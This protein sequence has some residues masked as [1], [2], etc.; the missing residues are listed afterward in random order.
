MACQAGPSEAV[1]LRLKSRDISDVSLASSESSGCSSERSSILRSPVNLEETP[2]LHG[3]ESSVSTDLPKPDV[4]GKES[5]A[6]DAGTSSPPAVLPPPH[7]PKQNNTSEI[8]HHHPVFVKDTSKYWYKPTISREQAINML[9]DK[10]P[11]TFVVRDSNSFPGA[12]GLAL[13]V[14]TPPPGVAP[15][16]G[17]ELVRHFLIEPSPK[18]VK[19]KG[20]NNEPVFGSLSA[21]VYQHS[22]TP[23]ALPT[24]LLLPEYDP[25]TTPEHVSA[26]QALLEQGAACN[27]AYIGSLDCESLTGSECVRRAVA[28]TVEDTQRGL[29]RPVS[30]HFKVSSQGVTLTDNTRKVFFRRHFPVNTVIFAGMDPADRKF[31]NYSVIGF[32]DQCVKSARLFAIVA[33]KP[34][35]MENACHVFAEFEPEQPATAVVNFINKVLF[36]N[37]R[38]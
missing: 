14:A 16:D 27:V 5:K 13:K 30:V 20:C 31:D 1:V 33:R 36:A 37:R 17:T 34:S 12:F 4:A 2:V 11:G 32:H 6:S 8:I 18:G 10:A 25:A 22:I 19:L 15:G 38:S 24:K 29:S 3:T 9:R 23:L 7:L 35:S 21:L 26:T 28:R